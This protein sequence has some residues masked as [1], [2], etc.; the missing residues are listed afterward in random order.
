MVTPVIASVSPASC[1]GE[2]CSAHHRQHRSRGN[3]SVRHPPVAAAATFAAVCSTSGSHS[4]STRQRGRATVAGAGYREKVTKLPV[5]RLPSA[6]SQ[7]SVA[8][9]HA[10]SA[11]SLSQLLLRV[12]HS[13]SAL[14]SSNTRLM[15]DEA[16]CSCHSFMPRRVACHSFCKGFCDATTTP[17][18]VHEG[19]RCC[20]CGCCPRCCCNTCFGPPLLLLLLLP[21][22][23]CCCCC[24][25]NNPREPLIAAA[26]YLCRGLC[27]VR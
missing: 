5:Q 24:C 25:C 23:Q 11:G 14:G 27:V 26:T 3:T 8:A 17:V 4:W 12:G 7:R 22:L 10:F 19:N 16:R 9:A 20:G 15:R 13:F 21:L 1:G 2:R 6:R 18:L